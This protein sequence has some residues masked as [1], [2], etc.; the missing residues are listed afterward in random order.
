MQERGW[1][2]GFT[3]M[4]LINGRQFGNEVWSSPKKWVL[5]EEE[6]M[7][8]GPNTLPPRIIRQSS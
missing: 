5:F 4:G 6:D 7:S 3:Q 8:K 1:E 2:E